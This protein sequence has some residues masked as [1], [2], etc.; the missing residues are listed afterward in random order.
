MTEDIDLA[1]RR[2]GEEP[3]DD[4][5][6]EEVDAPA[7]GRRRRQ[8]ERGWLKV[9]KEW[10]I[11]KKTCILMYISTLTLIVTCIN[12]F[13]PLA[14]HFDPTFN[15]THALTRLTRYLN[16]TVTKARQAASADDADDDDDW[17]LGGDAK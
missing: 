7:Q 16:M 5:E 8:E 10:I 9:V 11:L 12:Y 13:E 3:A 6:E 15:I 14:K 4:D 2:P 17:W 1:S